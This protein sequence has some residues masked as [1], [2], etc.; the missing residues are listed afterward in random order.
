MPTSR[1][2]HGP[3][4]D[5]RR[6]LELLAGSHDGCTEAHMLAHGF[7]TDLL[8]ELINAKLATA[9]SERTV[10]GGRWVEVIRF[11]ITE[12]GRRALSHL[13]WP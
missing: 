5:R 13:R 10:A 11:R 7:S 2:Y 6:A 4:A 9:Q 12:A 3:K 8:L 1:R